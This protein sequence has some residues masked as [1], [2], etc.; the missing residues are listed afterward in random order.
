MCLSF[1][2]RQI[3]SRA[4]RMASRTPMFGTLAREFRPDARHPRNLF[5][6]PPA[7]YKRTARP[8]QRRSTRRAATSHSNLQR[9]TSAQS[10]P[11]VEFSCGTLA[12]AF[13]AARLPR[14]RWTN[15][16]FSTQ[17]RPVEHASSRQALGGAGVSPAICL[18]FTQHQHAGETP[19]PQRKAHG[20]KPAFLASH[21]TPAREKADPRL[22]Q[23]PKAAAAS[24][25][26]PIPA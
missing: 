7:P 4:L 13:Q 12:P 1:L 18:I 2:P 16:P 19:A 21:F 15:S 17:S 26:I 5:P 20:P 24:G 25:T 6:S 8:L 3:W 10:H 23:P 11:P 14:S 22:A 9:P